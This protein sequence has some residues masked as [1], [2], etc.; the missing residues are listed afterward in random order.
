MGLIKD[1]WTNRVQ[2]KQIRELEEK[3]V[4]A[5]NAQEE[6]VARLSDEELMRKTEEFK[7]RIQEGSSL[8]DLF[9]GSFCRGARSS[10]KSNWYASL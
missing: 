9:G 7:R 10:K 3:Y 6:E 8:D 5:V 2:A 4:E 1:F